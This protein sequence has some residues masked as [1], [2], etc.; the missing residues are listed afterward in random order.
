M[1]TPVFRVAC[2]KTVVLFLVPALALFVQLSLGA[3]TT[4]LPQP[5]AG[6]EAQTTRTDPSDT[7]LPTTTET[8]F[9]Q[10]ES[11]IFL[12]AAGTAGPDS[13]AGELFVSIGP[14]STLSI[15]TT[16]S[17][18]PPPPT[19]TAASQLQLASYSGGTPALYGGSKSRLVAD[20]ESQLRFLEA[21]PEKAAA[22]CAA[23]SADPTFR[24]TGGDQI[25]PSQLRDYFA[26]LTPVMLVHDTRVTNHGYRDRR[27]TPRQAVLQAGQMV[28]V[29]RYGV[30]RVR[31]ECGNPLCPP[32]PVSTTPRYT[33]PRWPDFDPGQVIV[34]KATPDPLDDLVLV[35][36]FDGSTFTRPAGS[37]G[38]KDKDSDEENDGDGAGRAGDWALTVTL[39]YRWGWFTWTAEH[40]VVGADGTLS[41]TAQGV[42][43]ANGWTFTGSPD[44]WTGTWI[45][46]ITCPVTI[47][48]T[49]ED[50]PTGRI[51]SITPV[52]GPVTWTPLEIHDEYG[53]H[54]EK[55][56][57]VEA[58]IPGWMHALF[59]PMDIPAIDEGELSVPVDYGD[60]VMG[61]AILTAH[62]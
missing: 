46:T 60:G 13:F 3:C 42:W 53:G 59:L 11:E 38:D 58:Q 54:D 15:P 18:L 17:L 32:T 16:S 2:D 27:P 29:D 24:W 6:A 61:E 20:K 50:T 55:R 9:V 30:P 41:G 52:P 47:T 33:G 10:W 57:H 25:Q 36:T 21:N 45:S 8:V 43:I 28:L 44:N 39:D 31:C 12:E 23:L 48:G 22:F 5:S 1:R 49:V 62:R 37:S 4:S 40:V 19:A 51:L 26:E 14:T 7:L 56:A 35:D 34:V